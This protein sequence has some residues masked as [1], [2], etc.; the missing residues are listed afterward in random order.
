MIKWWRG[1]LVWCIDGSDVLIMKMTWGEETLGEQEHGK[2]DLG[3][4]LHGVGE[5]EQR[6]PSWRP[7]GTTG[8][9]DKGWAGEGLSFSMGTTTPW[10]REALGSSTIDV[11]G[12]PWRRRGPAAPASEGRSDGELAATMAEL[13]GG[14]RSGREREEGR[15]A[16]LMADT[17]GSSGGERLLPDVSRNRGGM[18]AWGGRSKEEEWLAARVG[19]KNISKCKGEGLYL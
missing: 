16:C 11:A 7:E 14:A 15:E 10:E 17:G 1:S 18:L 9:F 6:A 4:E 12:R 2:M 19:R 8:E 5:K 3:L 13:E